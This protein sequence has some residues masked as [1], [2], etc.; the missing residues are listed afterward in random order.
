MTSKANEVFLQFLNL[1]NY[2]LADYRFLY[3]NHKDLN[4]FLMKS[5]RYLISLILIISKYKIID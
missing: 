5:A 3:S 2:L 1:M 4:E